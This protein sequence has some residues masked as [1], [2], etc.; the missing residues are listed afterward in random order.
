MKVVRGLVHRF[1]ANVDTDGIIPARYLTTT[2]PVELGNHCMEGIDAGFAQRVRQGDLIV[3]DENFGSGS[4]REHAPIA[5]KA[6]GIQCV[7]ASSFARIFYRNA[8]NVGLPIIECP[9]VAAVTEDGDELEVDVTTGR[10]AN[11]TRATEAHAVPFPEFMSELLEA[12]GLVP[13]LRAKLVG[14]DSANDSQ[15][16]P[17]AGPKEADLQHD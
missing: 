2:D 3:A 16:V 13:Y 9:E 1:G 14:P 10:V 15:V 4:S 5:L 8:I 12:G 7:V 6:A 11:L 17:V